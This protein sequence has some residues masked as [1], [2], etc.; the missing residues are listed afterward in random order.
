ME[1]ELKGRLEQRVMQLGHAAKSSGVRM[2][3][4]AEQSYFQPAIDGLAMKLMKEY[5][6][7]DAIVFNTY[8]CYLK[9][10]IQL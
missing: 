2:L 10:Y 9:V 7:G 5:N 3:V 1:L 4:D 6:R 8:Q